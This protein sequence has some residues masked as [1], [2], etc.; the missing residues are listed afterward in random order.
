MKVFV[1]VGSTHFPALV[2]SLFRIDT[3][4]AL[5]EQGYIEVTVQ[6]GRDYVL[7]RQLQSTLNDDI[8]VL[9]FDYAPSIDSYMKEADLIISHAGM[10]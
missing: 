8:R 2:E 9:G 7:F 5:R 4:N 10:Q 6:Y 3:L 1:T